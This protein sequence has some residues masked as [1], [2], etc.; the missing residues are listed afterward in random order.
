MSTEIRLT[1][2]ERDASGWKTVQALIEQRMKAHRA[3]TENP[4]KDD[5]ERFAAACRVDELKEVLKVAMPPRTREAPE[6]YA[7]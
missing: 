2:T 3:I 7:D 5:R 1:A 6:G 4:H